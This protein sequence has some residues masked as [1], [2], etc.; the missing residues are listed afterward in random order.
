MGQ[1]HL[2]IVNHNNFRIPGATDGA[3]W[4]LLE[5][6]LNAKAAEKVSTRS[7]DLVL[8]PGPPDIAD[9]LEANFAPCGN[10]THSGGWRFAL[11]GRGGHWGRGKIYFKDLLG[12]G[13]HLDDAVVPCVVAAVILR[14]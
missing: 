14:A 10:R 8:H 11:R 1:Y 9:G 12:C 5:R 4:S 7:G 6:T 3:S 13:D 2:Q